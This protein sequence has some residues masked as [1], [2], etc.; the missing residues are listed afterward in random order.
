[1]TS[2]SSKALPEKKGSRNTRGLFAFMKI[3]KISNKKGKKA[4]RRH[5][6][7][8]LIAISLIL[9]TSSFLMNKIEREDRERGLYIN[10]EEYTIRNTLFHSLR[11]RR[12]R[13]EIEKRK[14]LREMRFGKE[15]Y[16]L[17]VVPAVITALCTACT[18]GGAVYIFM[19]LYLFFSLLALY[20]R[21]AFYVILQN[22]VVLSAI[23]T[24]FNMPAAVLAVGNMLETGYYIKEVKRFRK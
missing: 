7:P 24:A 9:V 23:L 10:E 18:G 3:M 1:M 19:L 17:A 21:R 13:E 15:A 2:R 4:E 8:L 16:V 12:R 14:T 22:V 20:E 6:M 11:G 5:Y